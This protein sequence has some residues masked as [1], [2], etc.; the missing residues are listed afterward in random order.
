MAVE[1]STLKPLQEGAVI[2][3]SQVATY[4]VPASTK[5]TVK[6]VSIH[7]EDADDE[8]VSIWFV[9]SGGAVALATLRYELRVYGG[10]T[11]DLECSHILNAA[12]QII[13][14]GATGLI[15]SIHISGFEITNAS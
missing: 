12:T 1:I 13:V 14:Q 15:A 8:I 3:T 2:T 7:N 6:F 11:A 10:T 4:T 5:A 9:P